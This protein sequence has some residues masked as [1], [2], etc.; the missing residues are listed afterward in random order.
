MR[1]ILILVLSANAAWGQMLDE[2]TTV[3]NEPNGAEKLFELAQGEKFYSFPEEE[4]WYKIRK[5]VYTAEGI[6]PGRS[7]PSGTILYNEEGEKI[8]QTMSEVKAQE[9]DT[10]SRF[11]KEDRMVA[12][13]EGYVFKTKI[14]DGSIPEPYLQKALFEKSYRD[15]KEMLQ[16]LVNDFGFEEAEEFGSSLNARV[17][18]EKHTSVKE[19]KNFRI[20]L[21]YRGSTL[22][23]IITHRHRVEAPK[24]KHKVED[25]PYYMI[26]FF[27]PSDSQVEEMENMMYTYMPL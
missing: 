16:K 17:L 13:L 27:K 14:E 19:D 11:R 26:Y 7:L 15:Q 25:D 9:A 8:G 10:L 22:Y 24:I 12:V 20:I 4:G 21:V 23:G 5:I 3:L 6:V 1:Y 18:Y 2:K